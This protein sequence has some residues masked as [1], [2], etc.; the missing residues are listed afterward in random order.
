MSAQTET[1]RL[2]SQTPLSHG[3]LSVFCDLEQTQASSGSGVSI[4]VRVAHVI[5]H[6]FKSHWSVG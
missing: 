1:D 4:P 6:I 2:L 5:I 3:V